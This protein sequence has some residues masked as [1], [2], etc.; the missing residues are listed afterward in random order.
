MSSQY[1]DKTMLFFDTLVE[2]LITIHAKDWKESSKIDPLI[3]RKAY[4]NT[5]IVMQGSRYLFV[6]NFPDQDPCMIGYMLKVNDSL[7]FLEITEIWHDM[8]Y[9]LLFGLKSTNLDQTPFIIPSNNWLLYVTKVAIRF[10]NMASYNKH[11]FG[12]LNFIF[13]GEEK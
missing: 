1:K 10:Y 4:S 6:S 7:T 11:G 9:K 2:C 13:L 3:I 8:N 12:D 5:S